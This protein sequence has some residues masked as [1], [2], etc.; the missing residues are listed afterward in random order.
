MKRTLAILV[1]A[2]CTA[3]SASAAPIRFY[4]QLD[5]PSEAPPNA[6]PGTGRAVVT[7]DK[8]ANT[9]RVQT[10]FEDLIGIVTVAHIHL[11]ATPLSGTGGV[12]TT[13]PT[14]PGFPAGSTSG[15]YDRTFDMT[16]ASSYNAA[17]LNNATNLGSTTTAQATLFTGIEEGRAYLNVHSTLYPGGEIRGFLV[18]EPASMTMVGVALAGLVARRRMRR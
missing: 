17:F 14:F 1:L 7:I 8:A 9:M 5:G 2:L 6:S 15:S 4:A 10:S 11:S 16:M 3:A 12:A 18:P 13:T